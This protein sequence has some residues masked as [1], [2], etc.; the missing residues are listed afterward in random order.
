MRP[1][2]LSGDRLP[3]RL[4]DLPEPP[5]VLY[6]R[7]E[8]P[9]GP[10]AAIVGTRTPTL[11]GALF[12]RKL[13]HDLARAGVAVLSGGA[14]G[15]DAEAH[16]GALSAR[17][18][19][20]VLAP[21]GF[22]QPYPAEH[23]RLFARIVRQGGAYASLVPDDCPATRAAFFAR[24]ACLVALAHVVVVIQ[25][26]Y[27]SGARNAAAA[28]KRLGRP[29]L[30][31]PSAPWIPQ[32]QGCLA[33]LRSGALPCERVSDVLDALAAAGQHPVRVPARPR[34]SRK[35][36]SAETQFVL[37]FHSH[38][39]EGLANDDSQHDAQRVLDAVRR[40]ICHVDA[41]AAQLGLPVARIQR[42]LLTHRLRGVLVADPAG[43]LVPSN[44]SE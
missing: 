2:L 26:G 12:A 5:E 22:L 17:G 29:L 30:C 7:G 43:R 34:R 6:V 24:N 37:P 8:L 35:R 14:I 10:C 27:R 44:A 16:R 42:A 39:N 40:G 23:A 13:A 4:R 31:V 3:A 33:E 32:G 36:R 18:S 25:A 15:I 1:S 19:T 28:A 20:A 11:E 38:A 9:R 21:A 41:L